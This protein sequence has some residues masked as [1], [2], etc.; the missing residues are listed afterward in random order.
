MDKIFSVRWLIKPLILF[1]I[2]N[3]LANADFV[4]N[5]NK[6][7][8]FLI[9]YFSYVISFVASLSACPD[10]YQRINNGCYNFSNTASVTTTYTWKDA[11]NFCKSLTSNQSIADGVVT[12]LIALESQA[13][14]IA[15][16]FWFKGF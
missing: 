3:H 13:E 1:F 6:I 5:K 4:G 8:P 9:L 10:N 16:S 7:K 2:L 14:T 11:D 12:H 15:L